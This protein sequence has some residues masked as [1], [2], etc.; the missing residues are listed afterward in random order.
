MT[1]TFNA[2]SKIA[3]SVIGSLFFTALAIGAAA[4]SVP[5]A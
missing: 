3:F 5:L 2:A 1:T 4:P